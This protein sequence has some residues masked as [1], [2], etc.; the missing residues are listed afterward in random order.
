MMV[1]LSAQKYIYCLIDLH[2]QTLIHFYNEIR[3]MKS[4]DVFRDDKPESRSRK[5]FRLIQLNS[6]NT[7]QVIV[8]IFFISIL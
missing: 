7:Y 4:K 3:S 2:S 5:E 6:I 8:L 1:S